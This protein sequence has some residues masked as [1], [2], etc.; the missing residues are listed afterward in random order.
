[1]ACFGKELSCFLRVFKLNRTTVANVRHLRVHRAL[2][3]I[4]SGNNVYSNRLV[5][6][7]YSTKKTESTGP[8]QP[9]VNV[10]TIGHIDHGK[11]T[12]TAAITKVLA[13][14]GKSQFVKYDEIDRA[15]EEQARG[16]TINVCHVHYTSNNRHYAHTDCP[17]HR[18]YIKNMICGTAQMDGAV[19]VVAATD[20][21]MPQTREHILLARQIGVKDIVVYINKVDLT[22]DEMVQL[23]EMEVLDLLEVYGYDISNV[24]VISGSAL[25]ALNDTNPQIG[26]ESILKLIQA[27]DKHIHLPVRDLEG[28][29]RLPIESSVSVPGRGTVAIGTLAQG[30][31]SRG[32][33]MELLGFG[34]SIKTTA[35]DLQVFHKSVNDV[36]AGDNV[37]VLLRGT[38][39]DLVLRGMFLAPPGS[40]TQSDAFECQLYVRTKSEGGRSKPLL[41]D[42]MNMMFVETWSLNSCIELPPDVPMAMPGDTTHAKILLRRPMVI[43][44]GQRFIIRENQLT[45]V[46]GLVTKLLPP[47][48]RKLVGFNFERPKLHKIE[49]NAGTVARKRR[50][51]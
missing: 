32:D 16:I 7:L 46:T 18:D 6:R 19:L 50:R 42:Y 22:D 26:K 14:Q 40:L 15:P 34:N 8:G 29:F 17:G 20:G 45:S 13:E 25:C 28:D 51:K 5:S 41:T 39:K 11:T 27:M 48:E 10:G 23:V 49:G 33:E 30:H 21:T 12:L 38:K 36:S 1:M 47:N 35:S 9:N 24:P 3:N 37:G 43:N 2:Y 4:N 44:V 31:L